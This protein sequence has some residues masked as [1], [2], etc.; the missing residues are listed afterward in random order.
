MLVVMEEVFL[1]RLLCLQMQPQEVEVEERLSSIFQH[2][3]FP[4]QLQLRLAPV[5]I[6]S[7]RFVR[8]LRGVLVVQV[9]RLVRLAREG[10]VVAAI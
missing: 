5:L 1:A 9:Y 6:R 7:A 3:L 2:H 10:L 8:L 4:A